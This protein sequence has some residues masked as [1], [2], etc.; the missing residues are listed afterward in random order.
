MSRFTS[1]K[2]QILLPIR[3]LE[4]QLLS[5]PLAL[6]ASAFVLTGNASAKSNVRTGGCSPGFEYI[7]LAEVLSEGPRPSATFADEM[8]NNDGY[9]CRRLLGDGREGIKNSFPGLVN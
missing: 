4:W 1:S 6:A 7:S 2:W 3:S 5:F 8:G 9:V